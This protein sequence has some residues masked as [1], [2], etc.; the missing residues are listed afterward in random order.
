MKLEMQI[1][2][3]SFILTAIVALIVL[4]ILK[5]LKIGQIE[6]ELQ[7]QTHLKKQGTPTMG[8]K[9]ILYKTSNIIICMYRFWINRIYRRF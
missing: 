4:P 9:R 8:I 3:A 7:P 5:K 6:R 2:T 1:L